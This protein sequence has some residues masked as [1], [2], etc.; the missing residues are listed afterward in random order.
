MRMREKY[1]I[2]CL[3]PGSPEGAKPPVSGHKKVNAVFKGLLTII[4][5]LLLTMVLINDID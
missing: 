5:M 2:L 1:D 4:A 3:R